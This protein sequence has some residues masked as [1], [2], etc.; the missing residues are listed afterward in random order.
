MTVCSTSDNQTVVYSTN[1]SLDPDH[2]GDGIEPFLRELKNTLTMAGKDMSYRKSE[3]KHTF[4]GE[5]R[6]PGLVRIIMNSWK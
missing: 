3:M 2:S 4:V 1:N 6:T 5:T